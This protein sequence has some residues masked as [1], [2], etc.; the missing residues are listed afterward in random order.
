[1]LKE[2]K[3]SHGD[4]RA[5]PSYDPQLGRWVKRQRRLY[6]LSVSGEQS[7]LDSSRIKLLEEIGF[8]WSTKEVFSKEWKENYDKLKAHKE[9]E[10]DCIVSPKCNY[11]LNRWIVEQRRQRKSSSL[12]P[13]CIELL[14]EID[15]DWS[16]REVNNRSWLESYNKL[17]IFKQSNGHCRVTRY[18]DDPQLGRWVKNQRDKYR[19]FREGKKSPLTPDRIE[20]LE[21]I[22]FDWSMADVNNREWEDKFNQ[23][24]AYKESFGHTRVPRRY[25]NDDGLGAWVKNQRDKHRLFREGKKSPLTPERI[26]L[27]DE[28]GFEWSLKDVD[29]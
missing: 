8:E 26:K 12:A 13:R 4:C 22:N 6:N 25:N 14:D 5:P 27:L 9:S 16:G 7:I 29:K 20:L 3:Q 15:F 2:Y 24:K 11:K 18:R 19:I 10:G 28:I 1:M 23:L 17:K 21:A